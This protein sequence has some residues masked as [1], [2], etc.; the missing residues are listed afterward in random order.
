VENSQRCPNCG[1]PL[2]PDDKFCRNCGKPFEERREDVPAPPLT[3]PTPP[4]PPPPPDT[5]GQMPPSEEPKYVAWEDREHVGFFE[6]LWKTWVESVFNP[7]KFFSNLPFKGGLGSPILYALILL[8]ITQIVDSVY[9]LLFANYWLALFR[10]YFSQYSQYYNFEF[11]AGV[12]LLSFFL[13]I[14]IAP[15]FIIIAIFIISGIY[16][17]ICMIFGW[18][19]RDFE[20]TLRAIAYSTGPAI[21]S[22]IP[23]CGAPIGWIWSLVLAII[24][25]KHM[26]KTSGGKATF[27][28][29]LPILL[30]CCLVII[31]AL[32]FGAALMTF[33]GK[34]AKGGYNF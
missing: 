27:V 12:S 4:T 5:L 32:I 28:I 11:G 34:A 19:K 16:H 6:A 18:A 1:F 22:I 21:I 31:F 20:A 9:R 30:C 33:I 7:D 29:L 2:G 24:G 26:Q 14:I 15:A 17:V 13:R 10:D 8:W 3:P 23:F 25:L